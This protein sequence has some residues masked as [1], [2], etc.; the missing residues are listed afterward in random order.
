MWVP[1]LWDT[2]RVSRSVKPHNE[3]GMPRANNWNPILDFEQAQ[4][5]EKHKIWS[6]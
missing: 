6:V 4:I 5:K 1:R 2:N 3:I